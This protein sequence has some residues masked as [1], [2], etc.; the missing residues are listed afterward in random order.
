MKRQRLL[1]ET[2][3]TKQP[4]KKKKVIRKQ[5]Q[6]QSNETGSAIE[7]TVT[8]TGGTSSSMITTTSSSTT[9]AQSDVGI[10]SGRETQE[11]DTIHNKKK[12]NHNDKEDTVMNP[13]LFNIFPSL[14]NRGGS[15][16]ATRGTRCG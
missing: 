13:S 4:I 7:N 12:A 14:R 6:Q 1:G 5:Q 2:T 16:A 15:R 9:T 3:T 8:P 11:D 10:Q